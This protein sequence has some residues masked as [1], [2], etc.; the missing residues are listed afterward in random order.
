MAEAPS[1]RFHD[2]R[3]DRDVAHLAEDK[4]G[5]QPGDKIRHGKF[6]N[7]IVVSVDGD[8]LTAAFEGIGTKHLSLSFA[9]V[10]KL[11]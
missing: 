11:P 3:N 1:L 6:G 10:E 7:G 8:D 5:L 4:T 2:A 9:P